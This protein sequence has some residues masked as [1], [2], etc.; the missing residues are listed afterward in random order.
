MKEI[1]IEHFANLL[2]KAGFSGALDLIKENIVPI[3]LAKKI[4]LVEA[5]YQ[6]A[7]PEEDQDTSW[8]QLWGALQNIPAKHFDP[9]RS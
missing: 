8:Y 1:D 7:D 9:F 2:E 6:Y 4:S 5:A 3:I